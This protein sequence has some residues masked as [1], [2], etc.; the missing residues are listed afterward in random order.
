M[1]GGM[2]AIKGTATEGQVHSK[3]ESSILARSNLCQTAIV[4]PAVGG[5][6][7]VWWRQRVAHT[8]RSAAGTSLQLE[9]SAESVMLQDGAE[10]GAG[11]GAQGCYDSRPPGLPVPDSSH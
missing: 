6:H 11:R 9:K 8:S 5:S 1:P 10:G 2:V 3:L 4:G 7:T